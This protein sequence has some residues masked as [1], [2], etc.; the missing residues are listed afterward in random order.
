MNGAKTICAYCGQQKQLTADH[1]PPKLLLDRPYPP[2]LW[3]V[4][5]CSDCNQAFKADDE[6]TRT[7]LAL[8]IRATWNNAAQVNLPAIMRSLQRRDAQGFAALIRQQSSSMGIVTPSGSPINIIEPERERINHTGLHILRGLYFR[9]TG[10]PLPAS[11]TVK[12]SHKAGL[13][14]DHPDI[15][16]MARLLLTV[17]DRRDGAIG[18]AFSFMAGI[19][20][21][22]SFWVMLLYEY[23][24]WAASIDDRPKADTQSGTAAGPERVQQSLD[25][26]ANSRPRPQLPLP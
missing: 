18:T 5:A 4:P 9:E 21:H 20:Q 13:T 16:T 26:E 15:L 25:L 17:A 10:H 24:F 12:L 23:F 7:V 3:V 2:N 11:A 6:Y 1:V 19:G 22:V 8:D 14:A